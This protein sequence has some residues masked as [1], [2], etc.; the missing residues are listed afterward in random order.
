MY[1]AVVRNLSEGGV[2][3]SQITA[4]NTKKGERR[5]T[6]KGLLALIE[7]AVELEMENVIFRSGTYCPS[8]TR[9][10]TKDKRKLFDRRVY[11]GK[12]LKLPEPA[13][14]ALLGIGLVGLA[15]AEVRRRRKKKSD[16]KS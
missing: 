10:N 15:G 13:T 9:D 11:C 16:N 5:I 8:L 1:K 14:I 6:E 7:S 3:T 4:F 12:R 2:F